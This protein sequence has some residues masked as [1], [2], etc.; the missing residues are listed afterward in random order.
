MTVFFLRQRKEWRR[1]TPP[2][3]LSS[4]EVLAKDIELYTDGGRQPLDQE[5]IEDF[6]KA[7]DELYST[8]KRLFFVQLLI[9]IFLV[10]NYFSVKLEVTL[11]GLAIKYGPGIPEVLLIISNLVGCYSI[12]LQGNLYLLEATIRSAI[13]A[14]VAPD[15]RA[16]YLIRYFPHESFGRYTPFNLPYL[17]P[18]KLLR[19]ASRFVATLAFFLILSTALVFIALNL[20]LLVHHLWL[21]PSFGIWSTVLFIYI[22]ALG[23]ASLTYIVLLRCRLP[24]TDYTTNDEIA[25]L[26][27][28]DPDRY[29]RRLNELYGRLNDQRTELE[30]RGYL[31]PRKR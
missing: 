28:I 12:L 26:E 16:I 7:R 10:T 8:I 11:L 4:A 22:L 30:E 1:I 2:V 15:L 25:L 17:I 24:Y 18:H 14:Q 3:W 6:A 27:Q 29:R 13:I 31:K 19:G 21:N 20:L 5:F 23:I 9:F